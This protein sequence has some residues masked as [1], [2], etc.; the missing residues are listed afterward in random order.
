MTLHSAKGLEFPVVF[1]VGMEDGVFPH[2]RTL[3]EPDELEEERRLAYVGIT[4]ARERLHLT[5]AVEP[6]ALRLDPVQPAEPLPRRDPG[7]LVAGDRRP[8]S[9]GQ[10]GSGWRSLA[11]PTRRRP[12][13]RVLRQRRRRRS[14]GPASGSCEPAIRA[15][16]RKPRSPTGR[17]AASGCEVGDDVRHE[18]F[19]EGVILDMSGA[20]DKA[21]ATV[22]FRE[23]GREALLLSWAPLE[24]L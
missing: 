24:K 2:L 4:R 17:R 21:E 7:E 8:R 1:L 14:A 13:G 6:D 5:H 23:A 3:G 9:V 18:K 12:D 16:Q 20:G 15:G 10:G 19:G 11:R 22:R